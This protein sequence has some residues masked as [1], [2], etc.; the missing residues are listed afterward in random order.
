MY[1]KFCFLNHMKIESIDSWDQILEN[2]G[3]EIA[4]K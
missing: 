3:F 2:Y 1:E 4:E